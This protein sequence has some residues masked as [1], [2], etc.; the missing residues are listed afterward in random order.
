MPESKYED[1]QTDVYFSDSRIIESS[2]FE[3]ILR[4]ALTNR[5]QDLGMH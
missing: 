3:R 4:F 1:R 5:Y 2:R